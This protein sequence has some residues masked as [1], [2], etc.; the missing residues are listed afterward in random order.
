MPNLKSQFIGHLGQPKGIPWYGLSILTSA[1]HATVL[2][3]SSKFP[4]C[5][6]PDEQ[7]SLIHGAEIIFIAIKKA[8]LL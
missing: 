5:M 4:W 3:K 2:L 8:R 6:I 7:S 1:N